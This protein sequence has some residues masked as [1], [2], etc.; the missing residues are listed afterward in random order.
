MPQERPSRVSLSTCIPSEV[1]KE[2]FD[3]FRVSSIRICTAQEVLSNQD[4]HAI[5]QNGILQLRK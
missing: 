1:D 3:Q 5:F 2:P 4:I